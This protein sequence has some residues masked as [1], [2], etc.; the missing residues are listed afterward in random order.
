DYDIGCQL[1]EIKFASKAHD[2]EPNSGKGVGLMSGKYET[3]NDSGGNV[4]IELRKFL[5]YRISILSSLIGNAI[6]R[7]YS[8]N[9]GLSLQEWKVLSILGHHGAIPSADIGRHT[10][11][12]RVA[13]SRALT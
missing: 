5:P 10:T 13:I 9:P 8:T 11:L 4:V 3:D 1:A 7:S 2:G 6:S 12:D